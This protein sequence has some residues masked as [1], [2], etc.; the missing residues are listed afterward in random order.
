M[1]QNTYTTSNKQTLH[2]EV[3]LNQTTLPIPG[4]NQETKTKQLNNRQQL[5]NKQTKILGLNR[6]RLGKQC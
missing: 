1:K 6:Y 4:K 5:G 2:G 3:T